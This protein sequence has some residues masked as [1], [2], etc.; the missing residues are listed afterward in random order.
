MRFETG[1]RK[2]FLIF[3]S[4]SI[5]FLCDIPFI[6]IY[7]R[8]L[9]IEYI[10]IIHDIQ[11]YLMK[12][13]FEIVFEIDKYSLLFFQA[14]CYLCTNK[15]YKSICKKEWCGCR[16]KITYRNVF[17]LISFSTLQHQSIIS[18]VTWFSMQNV[19]SN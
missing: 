8:F 13:I 10:L 9:L 2:I 11:Y 6:I 18:Q 15:I 16:Q 19:V 1:R 17:L 4:I 3:V 12:N 5:R 14:A 7:L